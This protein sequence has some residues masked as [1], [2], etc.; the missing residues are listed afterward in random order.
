M[1]TCLADTFSLFSIW[2]VSYFPLW[3]WET[4]TALE[5][6]WLFFL[7]CFSLL[8]TVFFNIWPAQNWCDTA[9]E[10]LNKSYADRGHLSWALIFRRSAHQYFRISDGIFLLYIV[11]TFHI[12]SPCLHTHP[13]LW[14]IAVK[15]A[16]HSISSSY[17]II[18]VRVIHFLRDKWADVVDLVA[19]DRKWKCS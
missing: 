10:Y 13:H 9:D 17:C 1:C 16:A 5:T 11:N 2:F 19:F 3:S 15:T 12:V 4:K 6:N 7:K 14:I 8:C 18:Q